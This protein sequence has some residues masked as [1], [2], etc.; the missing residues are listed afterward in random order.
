[1]HDALSQEDRE[2]VGTRVLRKIDGRSHIVATQNTDVRQAAGISRERCGEAMAAATLSSVELDY[3]PNRHRNAWGRCVWGGQNEDWCPE[4]DGPSRHLHG[5]CGIMAL[6]QL[7]SE[8]SHSHFKSRPAS[9]RG[10]S[11]SPNAKAS[12][13]PLACLRNQPNSFIVSRTLSPSGQRK[14]CSPA[15]V[16]PRSISFLRSLISAILSPARRASGSSCLLS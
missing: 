8:G 15:T 16:R 1:M 6:P 14:A 11:L 4:N 7:M 9:A 2:S 10:F 5:R 3:G 13:A 12:V